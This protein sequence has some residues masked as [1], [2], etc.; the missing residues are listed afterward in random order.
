MQKKWHVV[1]QT[2]VTTATTEFEVLAASPEEALSII[3]KD[4]LADAVRENDYHEHTTREPPE[5]VRL[6]GEEDVVPATD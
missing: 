6:K 2:V 4:P 1:T 5:F 3:N